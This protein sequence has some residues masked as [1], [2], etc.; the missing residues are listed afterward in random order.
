MKNIII[1]FV[2]VSVICNSYA[3]DF[4]ISFQS[5]ESSNQI[6]SISATNLRSNEIVKLLSDES[7]LLVKDPTGISSL[8]DKL[9]TGYIF[10]NPA[11]ENAILCF[12][13][14]KSQDVVIRLNNASGQ[15]LNQRKQSLTQGTHRFQLKFPLTGLYFLS[16]LKNDGPESFKVVYT[17]RKIQNSS[18][19]YA[20]SEKLN[21]Q[22]PDANQLK[23]AKI[24]GTLQY[25]ERDIILYTFFSGENTTIVTAT[26]TSSKVMDVEFV[27]CK[28]QDNRNYKV[29]KIGDQ[30]WMAEN[31]AWLPSVSPPSDGSDTSPSYYVYGFEGIDVAAAKLTANYN[32]FGVLY[33]WPSTLTSCPSDWHLPSDAE[34][35]QLEMFLGMT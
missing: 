8:S 4:T 29:V 3:Q 14:S 31:L 7:L 2:L 23:S 13:T 19:S 5:K 17:G 28:D 1:L 18:I 9:E 25:R 21:L 12:S 30:W 34:W 20:G 11:D 16:I 27:S 26:P 35:Q 32:T 6:D 22:K 24:N 10:P 33:N 15:L